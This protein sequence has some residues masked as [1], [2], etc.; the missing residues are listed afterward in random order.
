[1]VGNPMIVMAVPVE[2]HEDEKAAEPVSI[3]QKRIGDPIIKVGVV[4]WGRI[5]T[6]DW[7]SVVFIVPFNFRG[8]LIFGN[9][10]RGGGR[11]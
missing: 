4:P 8:S 7:R 3:P 5:I 2:I 10:R 11:A 6:Y 1:M 9:L